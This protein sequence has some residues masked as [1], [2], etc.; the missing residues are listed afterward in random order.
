[1]TH[2]A[3]LEQHVQTASRAPQQTLPSVETQTSHKSVLIGREVLDCIA[4][5]LGSI[6]V[7]FERL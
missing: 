6:R 1:M 4:R 2:W 5:A 3:E 7:R